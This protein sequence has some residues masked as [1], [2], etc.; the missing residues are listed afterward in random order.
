MAFETY[1][2]TP[3]QAPEGRYPV[4][5]R[6]TEMRFFELKIIVPLTMHIDGSEVNHDMFMSVDPEQGTGK[7]SSAEYTIE[8]L[9]QLGAKNPA[10]EIANALERGFESV[11]L[12]WADTIEWTECVVKHSK[13]YVNVNVY[14]PRAPLPAGAAKS[15]ASGLR[16]LAQKGKATAPAVN[17]FERGKPIAPPPA[18]AKKV[19]EDEIPF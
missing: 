16:G 13:G 3:D 19:E 17:P 18:V 11:D 12:S 10:E 9:E 14:K 4:R 7:K 1:K 6:V 15:V 8:A 2:A 5:V